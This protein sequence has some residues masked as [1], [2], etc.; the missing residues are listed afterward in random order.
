MHIAE[1]DSCKLLSGRREVDM[2]LI[3]RELE[4]MLLERARAY[5]AVT[6][7]GPRQSGKST[8]VREAFP[9]Y[10]YVS[11]EDIDM[12]EL[13]HDDPRSFLQRYSNH[14][15]LD[16]V[17]RVP[18][19]FSYMQRVMDERN[20]PGQFILSGSQNF[21]LL[22]SISQSLAGRVAILHLLPLSYTELT[23]AGETPSNDEFVFRG[24]YPRLYSS[25]ATPA[26]FYP[27]YVATYIDRD[28]RAELGVKKIDSFNRFLTLAALRI[29]E[30]MNVSHL[31]DEADVDSATIRN[32]LSILN[33][34]FIAFPL[35]PYYRNY[36]KRLVKSA[37]LYFYDT[38]LA[39]NLL[40]IESADQLFASQCRGALF[41]NAVVLEI[42]KQ[43][44]AQG[45]EPKLYYWRDSGQK[46]VDLIIERGGNPYFVIEIKSSATYRP[47]YFETLDDI[48]EAMGVPTERRFVV[49]GGEETI[50]TRHGTVIGLRDIGRL[51]R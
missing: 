11:L 48:A 45:K 36:G 47:K 43:Y 34:S 44:Q 2:P 24:G 37:K 12:R 16:E 39:A 38:G 29:G 20:E 28:V 18:E 32:W 26:D 6:L 25:L 46:E 42:V 19:L 40:G 23:H 15:I 9:D 17:Q 30:V 31:A 10:D 51:V 7:T 1:Y 27:G 49:Y 8:L 50:P 22:N 3:P 4:P 35:Q 14:V 13:A 41:E 21:L 5:P 33:A